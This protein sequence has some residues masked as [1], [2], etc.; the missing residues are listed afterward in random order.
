MIIAVIGNSAESILNFRSSLIR[1]I[2]QRNHRVLAFAPDF[3]QETWRATERLGATPIEFPLRRGGTNPF[4]DL[5]TLLALRRILTGLRPDAILCYFVKPAIYGNLAAAMSGV[6]RRLV[7][8]E[9]LG[10][11]FS[12]ESQSLQRRLIEAI[13][14]KLLRISLSK[15]HTTL[16]LNEDDRDVLIKQ[17]GLD[18]STIVNMG[19][20]GVEIDEF[21]VAP[22]NERATTFAMAAR[23][24]AEKGVKEY[25]EAARQIRGQGFKARFLLLGDVDDNPHSL[26]REQIAEWRAE[27]VIEWPGRVSNIKEWL[28][29]ADVFVLPSYYREGV[30]RS[31]QEAMALGRAIITTDHV[32][33][34]DTVD[35]GVNGI[36]VPPRNVEALV[37][38]MRKLID[39]PGLA[40]QMGEASRHLAEVRFDAATADQRI[41]NLLGA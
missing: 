4:A 40:Q 6:P 25:V 3:D 20:I 23:L 28:T 9:G 34:R 41:I 24:I 36:L 1:R 21:K 32:G 37:S 7:M 31:I 11:G 38:A 8:L 19:G 16:V 33:C 13:V 2:V 30:P 5:R 14:A 39:T 15:S 12:E 35:D 27:G 29:Q 22:V 10:Y 17:L 18:Q 26:S